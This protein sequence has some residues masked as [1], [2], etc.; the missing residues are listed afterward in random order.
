MA[1]DSMAAAAQRRP[2]ALDLEPLRVKL[3]RETLQ[4]SLENES[5][6]FVDDRRARTMAPSITSWLSEDGTQIPTRGQT[7]FSSDLESLEKSFETDLRALGKV[8]TRPRANS[9]VRQSIRHTVRGSLLFGAVRYE[10]VIPR[11][12]AREGKESEKLQQRQ[13]RFS[14]NE[15][16]GIDA[17]SIREDGMEYATGMKL[18]L[19]ITALC[20]GVFL[21]ALDNSIIATA[22]PRITDEF[23]SLSD[24]GWYGSGYMLTGSSFQLLFGKFYTFWSVKW[25]F[26]STIG[27][28]EL[29]SLVCGVAPNSMTLII[30]R[31]VA[32]MGSAGIFAGALTI[33]AYSVPL[34]KRPVYS[35]IIGSMW[36][37]SSVAGPLLGGVFT[38]KLSWR[39]CF[40]INLP[41]GLV[42]VVVIT[43]F[44]PDPK[45]KKLPTTWKQRI[46]QMDPIGTAAFLPAVVC[47]LLA[48]HW[49]G[50]QYSWDNPRITS[51]LML[52]AVLI[53]VFLYVQWR[54]Q[55]NATV[56]PR[57]MKKQTVWASSL[58]EFFIGACFLLA[59]YFL[60]IWFQ[61]VKGATPVKSGIMNIPMLLT[62]VISSVASGAVVSSWGYYTP[63]IIGGAVVMPI[64]YGLMS[65]LAAD[66]PAGAWIGYQVIAGVGVGIGMQ[67][68]LIAVQVVLDMVDVPTGTSIIIFMQSL[69]G[70]LF[71][72]AGQTVFTNRLEYFVREFAPKADPKAVLAAGATGIRGVFADDVLSGIV[73]AFNSALANCFWVSA[74]T[75]AT[76]I[77]GA[78]FVEWKSVKGKN[79]DMAAA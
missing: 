65:T 5:Q 73:T 70:A 56:P 69:G 29:G 66:S 18:V 77:V 11:V 2:K 45:R 55:D 43:I 22:I 79:V 15:A 17:A 49:G 28:F 26:L 16:D 23:H 39:W 1:S 14:E 6:Y 58:F 8:I 12:A 41:I 47:L 50:S 57:I 61:A 42:T 10:D 13:S 74:A 35:A 9:T 3:S 40:Y 51:L 20:F 54:M 76:A 31:A 36:G 75:A 37:I 24:V 68:P 27:V 38:D 33:L 48:L 64:G 21:M 67:Q 44:F 52:A 25:V 53:L 63:F 72:S 60:P 71:V 7:S 30:G 46:W 78:V 32:G 59:T 62:V 4:S 34:G 19:I